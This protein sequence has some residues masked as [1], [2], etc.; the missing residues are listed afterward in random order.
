MVHS[1]FSL[2][3]IATASQKHIATP[4]KEKGA[5][6]SLEES[7]RGGRFA[8]V[9]FENYADHVFDQANTSGVAPVE[10][11]DIK[12]FLAEDD[13][14]QDEIMFKIHNLLAELKDHIR[15]S[16]TSRKDSSLK[17]SPSS[18][19]TKMVK[20]GG[21][22]FPVPSSGEIQS[23]VRISKKL[24]AQEESQKEIESIK[25]GLANLGA[26]PGVREAYTKKLTKHFFIMKAAR[27]Y[28]EASQQVSEIDAEIR[29][30][31]D[32]AE[33]SGAGTL[34]GAGL[35]EDA[36]LQKE[37]QKHAK[38]MRLFENSPG[39]RE[40]LRFKQ[41]KEYSEAYAK[42]RMIEI[43]TIK[44]LREEGLVHMANHQPFLL[45]GHL[46][47][48]K[49][50]TAKHIARMFMMQNG[51]GYVE[52][53]S[54]GEWYDSLEPEIFSGSEGASVYDLVGK[55]KL[56]GEKEENPEEGMVSRIQKLKAAFTKAGMP[57]VP[58]EEITKLILGKGDVVKTTFN[59]GPFGRALK[60]GV[61]IIIDEVNRIPPEITSRLNDIMLRGIGSKF[62]L[63]EN[64]EEELEM[65]RGFGVLGTCNLGEQYHGLQEVD[66]AFKSRWVAREV[67]YPSIEETYD[68]MLA[69]IAR[70]D[71][72]RFPPNFPASAKRSL[73]DLAIVTR[74]IQEIFS[75]RTEAQAYMAVAQ[76]ATAQSAQ[77]KLAV[78][79]TRDLMRKIIK[80]WKNSGFKEDLDDIIAKNIL[81][82]EVFSIDDQRLMTELF[83]RRGFLKGW[84]VK[85][86][87]GAGIRGVSQKEIDVLHA[88]METQAYKDD[89]QN[90]AVETLQNIH[91]SFGMENPFSKEESPSVPDKDAM[92]ELLP[93]LGDA[94]EQVIGEGKELE[95]DE[96]FGGTASFEGGAF[97][98][99]EKETKVAEQME[100]AEKIFGAERFFGPEKIQK[101]FGFEPALFEIPEIP[102]SE[103]EME[104]RKSQGYNLVLRV[105]RDDRSVPMTPEH[106]I[107]LIKKHHGN[108]ENSWGDDEDGNPI[109]ILKQDPEDENAA[110]RPWYVE[111]QSPEFHEEH[112]E[113]RWVFE[114]SEPV[115]G[116]ESASGYVGQ[117]K[118]LRE[119]LKA[120]GALTPEEEENCS[121][122]AIEQNILALRKVD[123]ATR[124]APR[125]KESMQN[126]FG[127]L[128][129]QHHRRS[130]AES[131]YG[132]LLVLGSES[133]NIEYKE[134]TKTLTAEGMVVTVSVEGGKT[135]DITI[136]TPG[137]S[138]GKTST[139]AV[140]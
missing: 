90:S 38:A 47:S 30:L 46:G 88:Q 5:G 18:R 134:W 108:G 29:G 102:Y 8:K 27:L 119:A 36:L 20:M 109:K 105:A 93:K 64:G 117:T 83:M 26:I 111:K 60:R 77:L 72:P 140:I 104:L 110:E 116:S 32:D 6:D 57:D 15:T 121:D 137:A 48:G 28:D 74:E 39:G 43:P 139:L 65:P 61:P 23:Q 35:K 76:D 63:Q 31:H 86:L 115:K 12:D 82:A 49:T 127:L 128:I 62:K 124:K 135:L 54:T 45:A 75:G 132:I 59:Y 22:Y 7:V 106:M 24:E 4:H 112:L 120:Q 13:Y 122:D 85:K 98:K 136:G 69:A 33:K 14:K 81:G 123:P 131:L 52:G 3:S 40:F 80:P 51:V 95:S 19:P 96:A 56:G 66:A 50:E 133:S 17:E 107:E 94:M 113:T 55:L 10:Y 78:V 118:M 101:V 129:N 89:P 99:T 1:P 91:P 2:D 25:Q 58:H 79:S 70:K 126:L 71:R 114:G 37:R 16:K 84:D 67:F 11:A 100:A 41:I 97:R 9:S 68:L 125:A 53:Q 103:E 44:T 92:N 73:I 130:L 21:V 138:D 87:E 34:V 42:G